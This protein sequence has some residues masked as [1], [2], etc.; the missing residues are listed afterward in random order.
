MS[1]SIDTAA[2]SKAL[3]ERPARARQGQ[4][5]ACRWLSAGLALLVTGEIGAPLPTHTG[6]P[7]VYVVPIA[8]VIDLGLA[9]FVSRVLEVRFLTHPVVSLLLLT[10]GIVGLLV[11]FRTPGFGV[12]GALGITSLGLFFWGHC[13]VRLADW[14][15]LL[16]IGL[17]LVLLALGPPRLPGPAARP[18]VSAVGPA[19]EPGDRLLPG[20]GVPRRLSTSVAGRGR[21]VSQ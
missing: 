5:W 21:A 1:N 15:E 2:G 13:V 14:E 9:P 12:P 16:L 19:P 6:R 3:P 20:T 4:G 17:S 10:C 11:E 7:V 8:G 18:A